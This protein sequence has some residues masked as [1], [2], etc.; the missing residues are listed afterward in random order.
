MFCMRNTLKSKSLF[1][2]IF[3]SIYACVYVA[4]A[5]R[6]GQKYTFF[7]SLRDVTMV[8]MKSCV[9]I[10]QKHLLSTKKYPL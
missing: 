1:T 5:D 6:I 2:L 3:I 8:C 7:Q 10:L 9:N 4:F